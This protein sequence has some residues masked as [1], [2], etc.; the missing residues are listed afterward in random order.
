[1]NNTKTKKRNPNLNELIGTEHELF[2]HAWLLVDELPEIVI[3]MEPYDRD[4]SDEETKQIV[5]M[6]RQYRYDIAEKAVGKCVWEYI[7][8]IDDICFGKYNSFA[9]NEKED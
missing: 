5:A 3:G 6:I 4:I 9:D 7:S 8:I 2:R 1:M